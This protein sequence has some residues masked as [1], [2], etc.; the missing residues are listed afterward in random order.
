M[1]I[2]KVDRFRD[3]GPLSNESDPEYRQLLHTL[4]RA[5]QRA[6]YDLGTHDHTAL[7]HVVDAMDAITA[8]VQQQKD[9]T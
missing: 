7:Q 1:A 6:D 4:R 5:L 3:E 8:Y 2:V 9:W